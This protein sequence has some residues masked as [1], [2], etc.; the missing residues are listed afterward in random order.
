MYDS[1]AIADLR[2]TSGLLQIL[3]D[4]KNQSLIFRGTSASL[5]SA[6]MLLSVYVSIFL[7]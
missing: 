2:D 3:L 6:R 7:L 4:D 1:F 5:K